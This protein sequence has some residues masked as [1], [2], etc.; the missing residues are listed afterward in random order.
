VLDLSNNLLISALRF[1]KFPFIKNIAKID[2]AA[3]VNGVYA[4]SY[5]CDLFER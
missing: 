2:Y 5:F 1:E 3:M 4:G